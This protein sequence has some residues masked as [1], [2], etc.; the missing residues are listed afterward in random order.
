LGL[1]AVFVQT[2]TNNVSAAIFCSN[3]DLILPASTQH[4]HSNHDLVKRSG[5]TL[6]VRRPH[7]IWLPNNG[8]RSNQADDSDVNAESPPRAPDPDRDV[9]QRIEELTP[10]DGALV[11]ENLPREVSADV[12]NISIPTPPPVF[13]QRWSR[14]AT[15]SVANSILISDHGIF[16]D[17][18]P[19]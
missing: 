2:K 10:T 18:R 1:R 13:S 5:N 4:L 7:L 11:L 8:S 17:A 9:A 15:L 3:E 6:L 19:P 14:I 12:T 16:C